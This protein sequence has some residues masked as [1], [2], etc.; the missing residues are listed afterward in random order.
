MGPTIFFDTIY[1]SHYTISANFYIYLKYF[2]QKVF[3]FNKI[4]GSQTNL[5][6]TFLY[7]IFNLNY[8]ID[9]F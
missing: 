9:Q 8:K 2:Q 1:G 7:L 3:N 4:N 6:Y 5:R